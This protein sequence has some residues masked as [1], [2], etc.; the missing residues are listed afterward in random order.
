MDIN[1]K[2]VINMAFWNTPK[3]GKLPVYGPVEMAFRK[4]L[5][6][7]VDLNKQ[8]WHKD[9]YRV[10]FLEEDKVDEGYTSEYHYIH[11]IEV[12]IYDD[13]YR[14][15]Y[16][17]NRESHQTIREYFPFDSLEYSCMLSKNFENLV[18]ALEGIAEQIKN[19]QA[20][21]NHA[22][23]CHTILTGKAMNMRMK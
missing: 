12:R 16:I 18:N 1:V 23:C 14:F 17:Y 19:D 13:G 7:M 11:Y 20:A 15:W 8:G 2:D 21:F 4:K 22:I 5:E 9:S 3:K 10:V 6:S